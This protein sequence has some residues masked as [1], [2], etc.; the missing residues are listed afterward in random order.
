MRKVTYQ[1][2][3]RGVEFD[4]INDLLRI[5]KTNG[6]SLE[7]LFSDYIV[8]NTN[9]RKYRKMVED[10]KNTYET[11]EPFTKEEILKMV[12]DNKEQ[13][14]LALECLNS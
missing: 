4:N 5:Y 8:L 9:E 6:F 2:Y 1:F 7:T 10:I 13:R 3:H 11:I 14:D 12:P